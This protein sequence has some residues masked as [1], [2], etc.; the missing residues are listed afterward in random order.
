MRSVN[1]LINILIQLA[2]FQKGMMKEAIILFRRNT[3]GTLLT[4]RLYF[5]ANS[6]N[7]ESLNTSESQVSASSRHT[8]PEEQGLQTL[9]VALIV[10]AVIAV[11]C[12]ITGIG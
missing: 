3:V 6:S 12:T 7:G 5:S 10:V 9:S 2:I 1:P 8:M 11:I 4:F